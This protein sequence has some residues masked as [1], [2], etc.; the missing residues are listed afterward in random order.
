MGISVLE[1]L[2]EKADI[3]NKKE[4]THIMYCFQNQVLQVH[5]LQKLLMMIKSY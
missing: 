2:R 4:T 5:L 1:D 3:F